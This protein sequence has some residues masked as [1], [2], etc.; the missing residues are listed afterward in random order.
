VVRLNLGNLSVP[1]PRCSVPR[2]HLAGPLQLAAARVRLLACA[3]VLDHRRLAKDGAEVAGEPEPSEFARGCGA[4]LSL[5]ICSKAR[6]PRTSPAFR[7]I[8]PGALPLARSC[9]PPPVRSARR[10]T[11]EQGKPPWGHCG[12]DQHQ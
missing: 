6:R 9:I 12:V 7:V 8:G 10:S 3:T 2:V 4:A 1:R 5:A 11:D